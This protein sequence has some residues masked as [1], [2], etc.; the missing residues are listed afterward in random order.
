MAPGRW[1]KFHAPTAPS[2]AYK[3]LVSFVEKHLLATWV[4]HQWT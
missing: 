4:R 1:R 3:L 2:A